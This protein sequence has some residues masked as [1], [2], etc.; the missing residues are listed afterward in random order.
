MKNK[1]ITLIAL[2]ITIIV[3]LIL[4]GIS[5]ATLMGENG[6]LNQANEAKERND[7]AT[8]KEKLELELNAEKIEQPEKSVLWKSPF[9]Y[10]LIGSIEQSKIEKELG[11]KLEA[12]DLFYE[13]DMLKLGYTDRKETFL[14][15]REERALVKVDRSQ[16]KRANGMW[17]WNKKTDPELYQYYSDPQKRKEML[18]LLKQDG[19][20]ELYVSIGSEGFKNPTLTKQF[21]SDAYERGIVVEDLVGDPRYIIP[22]EHKAHAEDRVSRIVDYNNSAAYNEKIRGLHYDVEI[23]TSQEIE[24]L[25]KW[26]N[27]NSEEAKNSSRKI[28]YITLI[29]RIKKAAE[30]KN[31]TIAYDVPPLTYSAATVNYNGEEKSILEYV[32]KNS[33]YISCMSYKN[34]VVKLF[35][36]VCLP[37]NTE[38][39]KTTGRIA[40]TSNTKQ[41]SDG[42]LRNPDIVH[43]LALKHQKNMMVGVEIGD[44]GEEDDFYDL[45]KTKMKEVLHEFEE[46]LAKSDKDIVVGS[47]SLKQQAVE[48][49][50][51]T[52]IDFDHYGFIYHETMEY[53]FMPN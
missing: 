34:E 51:Y 32:V 12:T 20:T 45:G 18:D 42:T 2:V 38:Y 25:D 37:S 9:Q 16:L 40:Y 43:E 30:G 27:S 48:K 6:I 47:R 41:Y 17:Y 26:I 1:G 19:I 13:V 39:D 36:Q 5:I 22:S 4:A 44:P 35:R 31:I 49:C 46:L 21:V 24:G 14:Y 8:I 3:L 23:H 29:E 7:L 10:Q 33:D 28:N 50:N 15:N 52:N 53:L 11:R